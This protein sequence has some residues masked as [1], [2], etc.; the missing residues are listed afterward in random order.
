MKR[1][2]FWLWYGS[3]PKANDLVVWAFDKDNE[4]FPG[5]FRVVDR[6]LDDQC[7]VYYALKQVF[8][9]SIITTDD[10]PIYFHWGTVKLM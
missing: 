6:I 7:E 2:N 10:R 8:N 4:K 5:P 1:R 9:G 3:L